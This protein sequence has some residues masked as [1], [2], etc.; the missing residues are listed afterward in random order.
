M[1]ILLWIVFGQ[2]TL[3][4]VLQTLMLIVAIAEEKKVF[5]MFVGWLS[6]SFGAVVVFLA[7]LNWVGSV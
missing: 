4:W 1:Q 6:V 3:G 5:T 2:L 7:A